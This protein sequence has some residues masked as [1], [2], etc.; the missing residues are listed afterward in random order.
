MKKSLLRG[1]MRLRKAMAMRPAATHQHNNLIRAGLA[2]LLMSAAG[3]QAG[4][5]DVLHWSAGARTGGYYEFQRTRSKTIASTIPEYYGQNVQQ[6]LLHQLFVNFTPGKKGRFMA[7]FSMGYNTQNYDGSYYTAP[8]IFT[9]KAINSYYN[10]VV[11]TLGLN[12]DL[13]Y[14]V[15]Q[16]PALR[17]NHYAGVLA[18][19][20]RDFTNEYSRETT[21]PPTYISERRRNDAITTLRFGFVYSGKIDITRRFNTQ[22]NVSYGYSPDYETHRFNVNFGLGYSF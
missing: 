12:L 2:V 22:Y 7:E 11:R 3:M 6:G 8:G 17:W 4:A 14:K 10:G 9:E 18:G 13:K 21:Y 15:L 20:Q 16:F 19:Y 5:Q 1:A